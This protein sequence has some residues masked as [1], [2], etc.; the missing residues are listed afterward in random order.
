MADEVKHDIKL[1][2]IES[3]IECDWQDYK[4]IDLDDAIKVVK[5]KNRIMWRY[6]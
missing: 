5:E 1:F 3:V 6:C 2:I 4:S